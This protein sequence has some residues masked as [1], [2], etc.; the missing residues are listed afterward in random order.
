MKVIGVTGGV[1]AGKSTIL[2]ILKEEY[3]AVVIEADGVGKELQAKG[4]LC[5]RPMIELFGE[6][7]LLPD[8]QFDRAKLASIVFGDPS[9]MQKL[10]SIVHPA[11]KEEI[12]RRI[13]K[14]RAEKKQF[15]V[16]ESAI[17]FE[18]GYQEFCDEVWLIYVEKEIRIRRLME[19]R[20]YS[21]EKCLAIMAKQMDDSK[22]IVGISARINN[23][24]SV[25]NTRQQ[26]A[27]YISL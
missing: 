5:Y 11:V 4:G 21:R 7:V 9:M 2:S 27:S 25:E 16:V 24:Y 8:G 1:G 23:S 26:I 20:G 22:E 12:L 19:S 15:C 18:A 10:N 3:Q 17:F 6:E 13:A 14:A